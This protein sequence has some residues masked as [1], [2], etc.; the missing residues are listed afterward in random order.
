M[1]TTKSLP[2]TTHTAN[3]LAT[4]TFK[5]DGQA[6]LR[7]VADDN[8]DPWFVA[9]DIC[10]ALDI[11]TEQIRRL[12]DDEKGL[13]TIQTLGG[14]QQMSVVN[15]SG[16]YSL[17]FTSRK[18]EAKRF[19]KWVT[20][21]VLPALRKTGVYA[22]TPMSPAHQLLL[23]AQQL[24]DH[25]DRLRQVEEQIE[26]LHTQQMALSGGENYYT[27]KGFYH[28]KHLGAIDHR[29]AAQI[30][31]RAS[32]LSRDRGVSIGKATDP[33]YGEINTYPESILIELIG[34]A[35]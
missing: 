1:T 31:R 13:R 14:R 8:G 32:R 18:D 15:E 33:L 5:F 26:Q 22:V 27:I 9:A 30:G 3:Q 24:V 16:L 19:K 35:K 21:D 10:A 11:S 28:V 4:S 34:G 20:S 6:E 12:D 23:A 25:E 2:Q 17:V 29:A 7:V